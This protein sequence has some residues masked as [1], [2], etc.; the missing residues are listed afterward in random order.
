MGPKQTFKF[1]LGNV[2]KILVIMAMAAPALAYADDEETAGQYFAKDKEITAKYRQGFFQRPDT[3]LER[4]AVRART[5]RKDKSNY[6][7]A[8]EASAVQANCQSPVTALQQTAK[9]SKQMNATIQQVKA[10]RLI[11]DQNQRQRQNQNLMSADDELPDYDKGYESYQKSLKSHLRNQTPIQEVKAPTNEFVQKLLHFAKL[12]SE[13]PCRTL[14]KG[15]IC[16]S[17]EQPKSACL[18]GVRMAFQRAKGESTA[19]TWVGEAKKAGPFLK[20][21]GYHKIAVS[22]FESAPAGSVFI[23]INTQNARHAGHIEIKGTDGFYSDFHSP[24]MINDRRGHN[25]WTRKLT[26]AWVPN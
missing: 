23:Y 18:Q 24:Y 22:D 9:W 11:A 3:L 4:E 19:K 13:R 16:R 5:V 17:P 15:T 26:E 2:A 25:L 1:S 14:K 20:K 8:E 6:H 21:Y 10:P 12:E 7:S